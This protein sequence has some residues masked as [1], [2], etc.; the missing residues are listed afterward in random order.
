MKNLL[1]KITFIF[2]LIFLTLPLFAQS[3]G[4][5]VVLYALIL[6]AALIIIA[7]LFLVA[8][9]LVKIEGRNAGVDESELSMFGSKSGESTDTGEKVHVL[10]KGHNILLNGEAEQVIRTAEVSTFALQPP[11]FRGIAPIPKVVVEEGTSVAAGDPIFYDKT[12]PNIKY[13]A[14]VSGEFV[15]LNR[16]EKRAVTELV[17][18]ADK[19]QRYRSIPD[20]DLENC[21]RTDIVNFLMEY[22]AWPLIN[23]RPFDIVP[24]PE[25]APKNIFISTFSTAPLAPDYGLMVKGNEAAFQAGL[26]IL[27]KL[28]TGSV[29]LGLNAKLNG[30]LSNAFAQAQN[31]QKHYF[32]GPHPA[33]NVGVQI[34]HTAPINAGDSVWTLGVQEVI[35]IGRMLTEKRFNT[36]KLIAIVGADIN[37]P[38]YVR[39]YAGAHV[40]E[41]L[42]GRLKH[43]HVRMVSGDV[44]SGQTK[45]AE[46]YLNTNDDQLTVL[47]EGDEYEMFGWLLPIKPRPTISKT[48][49]NFM[50]P[51]IKFDATTNTHGEERAFVVSG[52]YES[53][54]PMDIYPQHLMKAI[55][56][57]DLERMEGL[58][59]YELSEEDLALCEFAC[60]SKQPLQEILR[61]GLDMMRSQL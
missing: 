24:D 7:S 56:M 34:H 17:I 5:S 37:D 28:T 26:N 10:K 53:V 35:I 39:T 14:P 58:G 22:G 21:S 36:E 19:D 55:M 60:T 42:K 52:Q 6:V 40:G 25:T 41:L 8:D 33:G 2:A 49:P 32:S 43:D 15:K 50:F 45:A 3:S 12:N 61:E 57:G 54:L 47:T 46:N 30:S 23:Q 51:D 4:S 44:L 11:N 48:F 27:S 38:G 18:L 16:G 29:H 1:A 20:L 9:N 31:V 59:I 13:V